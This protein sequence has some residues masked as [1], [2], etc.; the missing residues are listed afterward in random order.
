MILIIN[1]K[2]ER[3]KCYN[4]STQLFKILSTRIAPMANAP[5]PPPESVTD[6]I[7]LW[8]GLT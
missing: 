2:I 1:R 8:I 4:Y 7:T 3:L 6:F 5:S